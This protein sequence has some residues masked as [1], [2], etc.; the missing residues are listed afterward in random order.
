MSDCVDERP[1]YVEKQAFFLG[2][3]FK[4]IFLANI[5]HFQDFL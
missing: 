1:G 2:L 3:K 4:Y 5:P